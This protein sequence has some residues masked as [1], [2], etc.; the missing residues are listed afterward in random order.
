MQDLYYILNLCYILN[1]RKRI[2]REKG[3]W[4]GGRVY[5]MLF[6]GNGCVLRYD[7]LGRLEVQSLDKDKCFDEFY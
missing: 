5:E 1:V 6:L 7:C 2:K 4:G 3:G